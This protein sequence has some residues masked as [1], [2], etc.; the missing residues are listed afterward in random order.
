MESHLLTAGDGRLEVFRDSST[1]TDLPDGP[2]MT[3][4]GI[5]HIDNSFLPLNGCTAGVARADIARITVRASQHA[6]AAVR[7]VETDFRRDLSRIFSVSY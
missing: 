4:V 3:V 5:I 2:Y 6:V 7:L 1:V